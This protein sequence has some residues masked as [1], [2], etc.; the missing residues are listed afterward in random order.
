MSRIAILGVGAIGSIYG[1]R[2]YELGKHE[3]VLCV[4]KTF[5]K[6][7]IE[8]PSRVI[9]TPVHC[10]TLPEEV[11]SV[12]W[13]I[14]AVK[15][16]QVESV[17]PWFKN[18][19]GPKTIVAVLQ[20]G[21]EHLENTEPFVCGAE[22]LPVIVQCPA[23]R[24]SPGHVV[25][26][27]MSRLV[28]PDNE[29]GQVLSTLYEGS[30]IDV[31]LTSD[32]TTA[33]WKKLCGNIARNPATALTNRGRGVV[34]DSEVS[35]V[36]QTLVGECAEVG[37]AEGAILSDDFLENVVSN[38]SGI[39][40]NATTSMLVDVR[41]GLPLESEGMTGAVIRAGVKHGIPTPTTCV[42]HS[43]LSAI[44]RE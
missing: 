1:A 26:N 6:F 43:L 36:C 28:V 44:N 11:S 41:A 3:V 39:E 27:A 9:E 19:V 12:D 13:I 5:K 20:N 2:L 8:T 23:D 10:V 37:R 18:L 4:R 17:E 22:I 16:H 32:F 21:V 31:E 29:S 33:M 7:K 14:L 34:K 40:E 30:D 38:Q 25:Q 42:I 15:C 24:L 35:K